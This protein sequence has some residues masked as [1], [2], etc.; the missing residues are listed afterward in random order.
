MSFRWY[1]V[2]DWLPQIMQG[3]KV[4]LITFATSAA[5][6]IVLG[7]IIATMT[8]SK[9]IVL[10][11]FTRIYVT[12][13]RD[14]PL[15][16][17]LFF[18]FFGLPVMGIR[19]S[20]FATG[21]LGIT[22]NESAFIAEIVRGELSAI[23]ETEWEAGYSLALSK[24]QVIT[25]IVLPQAIRNAIPAVTG[26]TS[27]ILKDTSLLSLIMMCELTC[28]AKQIHTATIT[29]TGFIAVAII[30]EVLFWLITLG[31]RMLESK[32]RVKR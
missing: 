4:T 28:V 6:S 15:L 23:N 13:F 22:L 25:H 14:L 20:I 21:I 24:L 7:I 16:V 12:I 17:L 11:T 9:N 1:V 27:I 10:T 30:Y 3:A 2:I 8:L 18:L 5:L 19:F 26:Q 29:T 31:S 32:V